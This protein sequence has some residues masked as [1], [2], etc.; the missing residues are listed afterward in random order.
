MFGCHI[1]NNTCN[2][3]YAAKS[4]MIKSLEFLNIIENRLKMEIAEDKITIVEDVPI[5]TY[6]IFCIPKD[7]GED[8][9]LSIVVDLL[10]VL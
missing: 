7:G 1:I 6:G 4:K 8:D 9:R 5:C 2:T 10:T 3:A